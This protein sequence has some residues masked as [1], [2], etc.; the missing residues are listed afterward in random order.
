MQ[1][2]QRYGHRYRQA[3][4]AVRR[5]AAGGEPCILCGKPIDVTLKYPD[6]M[7]CTLQHIKQLANGGSLLDPSN[8]APSHSVCNSR[9]GGRRGRPGLSTAPPLSPNPSRSW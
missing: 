3:I 4:A 9:D 8:H 5:R 1:R 6:P 7:S 2:R